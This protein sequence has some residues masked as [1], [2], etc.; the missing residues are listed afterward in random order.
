M[1]EKIKKELTLSIIVPFYNAETYIVDCIRSLYKQDIPI[2]EY[3]VIAVDDGSPDN[4]RQLV[5]R[6]QKEYP[7]LRLEVLPKNAKIGGARNVGLDV[8]KGKYIMFVDSDDYLLSNVL[9]VLLEQMEKD[10]LDLLEFDFVSDNNGKISKSV[11]LPDIGVCKGTDLFFDKHFTWFRD[12]V[13]AW[14]K[15]YKYEFLK[16]NTLRFTEHIMYEDNDF[17]LQVF[18]LSNKTRHIAIDCYVYRENPDSVIRQSQS[19]FKLQSKLQSAFK[20]AELRDALIKS[21]IRFAEL[22]EGYVINSI[23]SVVASSVQY[24]Y[25]YSDVMSL[26]RSQ[27]HAIRKCMSFRRYIKL[28]YGNLFKVFLHKRY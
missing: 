19:L 10:D 25:K 3:E 24:G 11:E 7:N 22:V 18:S 27:W 9:R 6:L 1:A 15:L 4:S 14:R 16:K 26:T 28:R 21:N 5:E 17:A 20:V 23:A 2:D 13:V 8:A 12:H